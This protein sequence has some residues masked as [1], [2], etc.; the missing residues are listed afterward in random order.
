MPRLRGIALT[1][2]L[3]ACGG[4]GD[5]TREPREMLAPNTPAIPT[6]D[7]IVAIDLGVDTMVVYSPNFYMQRLWAQGVTR[8]G[9]RVNVAG[10]RWRSS[11]PAVVTVDSLDGTLYLPTT[12]RARVTASW[13]GFSDSAEL[14]VEVLCR[15][16]LSHTGPARLRVGEQAQ[17]TANLSGCSSAPGNY[18]RFRSMDTTILAMTPEGLGTARR[19]GT[20]IVEATLF[21]KE[22]RT[23]ATASNIVVDP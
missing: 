21:V 16:G 4:S 13:Q 11:N 20:T 8:T 7:A 9:D 19:V 10:A 2:F 3:A 1:L 15:G 22:Q 17:W 5:V 23:L 18:V 14:I 6:A 12:G